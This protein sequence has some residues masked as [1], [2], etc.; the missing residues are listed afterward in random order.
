[1]CGIVGV[2]ALYGS[3]LDIVGGGI[4]GVYG[5]LSGMDDIVVCVAILHCI[6]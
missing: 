3:S 1:M 6:D 4:V 5:S 2:V